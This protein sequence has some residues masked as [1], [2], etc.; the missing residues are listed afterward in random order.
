MNAIDFHPRGTFVTAGSDGGVTTWDKDSKQRLKQFNLCPSPI[1]AAK[2]NKPGTLLAYSSGYDWSQVKNNIQICLLFRVLG[3][4]KGKRATF[5]FTSWQML[6]SHPNLL[7]TRNLEGEVKRNLY[8]SQSK[9][10]PFFVSC[11]L[12]L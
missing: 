10:T 12:F 7:I 5:L 8:T 6:T 4:F 1:T 11:Y 9:K 2:F 3:D